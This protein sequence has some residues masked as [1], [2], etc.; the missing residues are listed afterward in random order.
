MEIRMVKNFPDFNDRKCKFC[1]GEIAV[2]V[3]RAGC[4]QK[5]IYICIE[6]LAKKLGWEVEWCKEVFGYGRQ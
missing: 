2:A 4:R 5:W 6:C 1:G 3:W